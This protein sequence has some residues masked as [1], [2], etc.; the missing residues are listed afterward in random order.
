MEL[1]KEVSLSV[2]D[3]QKMQKLYKDEEHIAHD[4]RIKAADADDKSVHPSLSISLIYSAQF[5]QCHLK[6]P[7]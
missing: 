1:Q 7:V 4:S 6:S 3:V 2:Q 5:H